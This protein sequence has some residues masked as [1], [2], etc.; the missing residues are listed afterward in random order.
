MTEDR[1]DLKLVVNDVPLPFKEVKKK[2][3]EI[4]HHTKL[5]L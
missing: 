5:A 2:L 3:F 4:S 1:I